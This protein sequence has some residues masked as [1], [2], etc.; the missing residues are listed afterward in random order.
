MVSMKPSGITKERNQDSLPVSR[1]SMEH[2]KKHVE[3]I[4][5][6]YQGGHQVFALWNVFGL[7][8]EAGMI[9]DPGQ[10]TLCSK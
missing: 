7:G 3:K 2:Q 8:G 4:E 5:C 6:V 10:N 1:Q 9:H